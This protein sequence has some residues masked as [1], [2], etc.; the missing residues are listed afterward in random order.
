VLE[1]LKWPSHQALLINRL[2]QWLWSRNRR[3]LARVIST[4]GRFLTG[5]E[6]EPGSQVGEGLWIAHGMGTVIGEGVRMGRDCR[7]FHGVTLGRGSS[8]V[9][10]PVPGDGYPRLGD[11]VVIYAN[12]TILG[13]ICLGDGSVVAAGAVVTRDVPAG[14]VVAGVP[15][16]VI[17]HR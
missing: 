3:D 10:T 8:E 9:S 2:T 13:P 5:I 15:A 1:L 4:L 14:A 16:R 6:I 12:A 17:R 11:R 7:I